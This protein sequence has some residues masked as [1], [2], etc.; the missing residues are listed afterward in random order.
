MLLTRMVSV[1][2]LSFDIK[3]QDRV[4]FVTFSNIRVSF[5][6]ISFKPLTNLIAINS[7]RIKWLRGMEL[8]KSLIKGCW[9]DGWGQN[10]GHILSIYA[11]FHVHLIFKATY[12]NNE[13]AILNDYV[14]V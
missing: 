14:S 12:T 11:Y 9:L 13:P 3:I 1:D 7:I 5:P 8:D 2:E 10:G 4:K 6:P